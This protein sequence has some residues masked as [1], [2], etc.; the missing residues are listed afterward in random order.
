MRD[1]WSYL[2]ETHKPILMY[3]MGNGA[4]KI[5][6][7]CSSYGIEIADFF[8]SDGFVRGHSFHGK[9]V[10]SYSEACEKY[11]DFIVLLS[12]AS[13]L[14]DVVERVL[15]IA[16]EHELYAPDVPVAGEGLFNL[17]YYEAHQSDI[18]AARA[19]LA[20]ERSRMVYDRVIEYKLTGRVDILMTTAGGDDNTKSRFDYS[21]YRT[22]IDCG[23]YNGDTARELI[24]D[25]ANLER[26]V[27][28][29][30]DRRNFKKLSAY[31]ENEPRVT[32]FNCG[33]WHENDTL[34][35][36]TQGSRNSSLTKGNGDAVSVDSVDNIAA[37]LGI[38]HVDYIKYDVEGVEREALLGS[39]GIIKRDA[40]DLLVSAYHRNEDIF[41]LPL[42][43]HE[44]NPNYKLYYRR[45]FYIPAWDLNLCAKK[46]E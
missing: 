21:S 35:F 19:L 45:E 3:G 44:L 18:D 36:H 7:V 16:E 14:P 17:E 40:P 23:A 10:L 24:Q 1:L 41:A 13:S 38:G 42:L 31:A 22:C 30:P 39:A 46:G 2:K 20:D 37:E 15:K 5:L 33:V 9:K 27:S 29:E 26:V 12:F 6:A 34:S 4:D 43:L 28:L 11:D 8:A 25:C 32:A